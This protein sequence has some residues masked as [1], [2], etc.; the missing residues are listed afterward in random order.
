MVQEDLDVD[1]MNLG[2]LL[3]CNGTL[4]QHYYSYD[5]DHDDCRYSYPS[6]VRGGTSTTGK[7]ITSEVSWHACRTKSSIIP[8]VTVPS[9]LVAGEQDW[10][11]IDAN[12]SFVIQTFAENLGLVVL[13]PVIRFWANFSTTH[14]CGLLGTL[15]TKQLNS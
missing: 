3:S 7:L 12:T 11:L 9:G 2:L 6:K 4:Y 5:H 15:V 1:R 13:P 10:I 14:A 8:L